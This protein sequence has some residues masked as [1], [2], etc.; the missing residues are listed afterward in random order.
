MHNSTIYS[1]AVLSG[2]QLIWKTGIMFFRAGRFG[3]WIWT[4]YYIFLL[5][6]VGRL[7]YIA[8]S[9]W[10]GTL[11][12]GPTLFSLAGK[13]GSHSS[14][15]RLDSGH[16]GLELSHLS[17]TDVLLPHWLLLST[18]YRGRETVMLVVE[19]SCTT[20]WYNTVDSMYSG[21]T[22]QNIYPPL[23]RLGRLASLAKKPRCH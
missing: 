2:W 8:L 6:L 16:Q 9:G 10:L 22:C 1:N 12:R 19:E 23:R 3:D 18:P 21:S 14:V 4:T 7:T 5:L 20:L 15:L 11:Y 13:F 17:L